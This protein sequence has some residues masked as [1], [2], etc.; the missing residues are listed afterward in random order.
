MHKW[1]QESHVWIKTVTVEKEGSK[2]ISKQIYVLKRNI[3]QSFAIIHL[4]YD[5]KSVC[6]F[7]I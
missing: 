4:I 3:L 5:H 1:T 7:T 6:F 2:W